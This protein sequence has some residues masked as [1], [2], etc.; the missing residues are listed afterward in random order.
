[1]RGL[2]AGLARAALLTILELRRML[3]NRGELAFGLALPI[4]LFALMYGAFGQDVVFRGTAHV[5]DLDGG[6]SA[7][8]FIERLDALPEISVRERELA[9]AQRALD[10]SAILLA[11]VIPAGFS[12]SLQRGETATLRFVQHGNGGEEGQVVAALAQAIAEGLAREAGI[13]SRL[14]TALGEQAAAPEQMAATVA[15]LRAE[16]P[17]VGV[18]VRAVGEGGNAFIFRMVAGLLVMFVMF[19]VT[20]SAQYLVEERQLGTLERLLTTR[21]SARSLFLGKFLAGIARGGV[22]ALL[23]LALAFAAFGLGGAP[24]FGAMLALSALL[25]AA[26][27][28]IGLV[29]GALAKTPDQASWAAAFLTTYMAIFGGNF[30]EISNEGVLGLIS[31]FTLN[32]HVIDAMIAVLAAGERWWQQDGAIAL[33]ALTTLLALALARWCFRFADGGGA[34]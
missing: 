6:E 20:L 15:E 19:S 11:I 27:S 12:D 7:R 10:R 13:F 29:I 8:A 4:V 32:R 23:L 5:V 17:A 28:A 3:V 9:D 24:E 33:M 2:A 25:L 22:Q 31:Q 16:A 34:G 14:E 21:L 26:V 18:S 30:I 1:M